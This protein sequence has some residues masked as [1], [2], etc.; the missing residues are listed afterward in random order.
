MI[1]S[2]T[3]KF[4]REYRCGVKTESRDNVESTN[5]QRTIEAVKRLSLLAD[6]IASSHGISY[7]AVASVVFILRLWGKLGN[8]QYRLLARH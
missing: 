4:A 3:L 2:F 8:S 5:Y 1:G 7:N 6:F